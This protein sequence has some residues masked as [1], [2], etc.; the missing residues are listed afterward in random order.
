M[1]HFWAGLA[2]TL[3]S[4]SAFAAPVLNADNNHYYDFVA[5]AL[6][7]DEALAAASA[8][9]FDGRA[10]YLVTVTSDSE[11]DF[12]FNQVTQSA[13]WLGGTDRDVEGTWRWISGPEAGEAF[14]KDGVTLTYSS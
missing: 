2:A 5:S 10:G 7:F 11:R 14:W 9:T 3:M 12:I 13:Y 1:K 4:G 8:M 6:S